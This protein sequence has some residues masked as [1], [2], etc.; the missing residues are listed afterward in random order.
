MNEITN[1]AGCVHVIKFRIAGSSSGAESVQA[2]PLYKPALPIDGEM[3]DAVRLLNVPLA[4]V[5]EY[6][7]GAKASAYS[8]AC[9]VTIRAEHQHTY[10]AARRQLIDARVALLT[11]V[12]HFRHMALEPRELE[13][14]RQVAEVFLQVQVFL[15]GTGKVSNRLHCRSC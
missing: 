3:D 8:L 6:L 10:A 9:V 15:V 1:K 13:L 11:A 2:W 4:V 5:N 14:R 7:E 12:D